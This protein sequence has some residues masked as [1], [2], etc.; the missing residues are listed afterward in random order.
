[1]PLYNFALK[2]SGFKD[3]LVYTSKTTTSNILDKKQRKRMIILFNPPYF[4]NVKP[5]FGKTF[6]SLLKK[7]FPKKYKLNKISNKNNVKD[8]LQLHEQYIINS[9]RV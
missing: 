9:S 7:H 4:V 2:T 5:N 8:Q 1:M 6:S 3:K